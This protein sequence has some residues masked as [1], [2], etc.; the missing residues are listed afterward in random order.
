[1]LTSIHH[2]LKNDGRVFMTVFVL[3][4]AAMDGIQGG[5]TAFSFKN[6]TPSG[7][8]YAERSDDPTFAVAYDDGLLDELIGSAGFKLER[9]VRGYWSTGG[10]GETFQDV[11]ILRRPERH[12]DQ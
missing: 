4:A 2:A 8:L 10:V 11:L 3:D 1:M 9:R 12:S 5:Q 6:R 7:K